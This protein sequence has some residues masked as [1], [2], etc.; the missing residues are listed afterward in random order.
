MKKFRQ[1]REFLNTVY[2]YPYAFGGIGIRHLNEDVWEH[3]TPIGTPTKAAAHELKPHK[4]TLHV[5]EHRL[6]DHHG[7]FLDENNKPDYNLQGV[8]PVKYYGNSSHGINQALIQA[9]KNGTKLQLMNTVSNEIRAAHRGLANLLHDAPELKHPMRVYTGIGPQ[10]DILKER[11][12]GKDIVHFP[13]FT[14]TSLNPSE[15]MRFAYSLKNKHLPEIVAIDLPAGSYHGL[16]IGN[17]S[18]HPEEQEFLLQHGKNIRFHEDPREYVDKSGDKYLVHKG[19][20][21]S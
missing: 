4:N 21:E 7:E 17:H 2:S 5:I 6:L 3:G 9:H 20:I 10:F 1:L 13:A 8:T 12:R 16:Y 15:A 14:S 19:T 18:D 11:E